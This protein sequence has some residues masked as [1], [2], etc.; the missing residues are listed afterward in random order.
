M[1]SLKMKRKPQINIEHKLNRLNA[2]AYWINSSE[3]YSS[4]MEHIEED[5]SDMF[6]GM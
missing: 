4:L 5:D 3:F 2:S 1:K 6:F